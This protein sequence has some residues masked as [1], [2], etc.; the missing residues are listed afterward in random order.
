VTIARR[1]RELGVGNVFVVLN[2]CSSENEEAL[3]SKELKKR[4]LELVATIPNS[5]VVKGADLLGVSPMDM[6][7]I[8]PLLPVF[9]SIKDR[10]DSF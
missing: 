6:P 8:E 4:Q 7:G 3:V 9:Q 1:A 2:K 5:D 10:I